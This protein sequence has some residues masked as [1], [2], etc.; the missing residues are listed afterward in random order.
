MLSKKDIEKEL[1]KGIAVV[2]FNKDNLKD[3]S[4]NLTASEYAWGTVSQNYYYNATKDI[5]TIYASER[6]IPEFKRK[7]YKTRYIRAGSSVVITQ[8]N[9]KVILLFPNTT[10]YV[11]TLEVLSTGGSIGGTCHSKVGIAAQGI[12]HIG[13][14]MG[15]N[16][17]GNCFVPL[18][19]PTNKLIV[20]PVGETFMSV[21]FNYLDTPMQERNATTGG[22]T[23]KFSSLGIH[24][25]E[26][27]MHELNQDWKRSHQKVAEQMKSDENFINYKKHLRRQRLSLFFS[28]KNIM[29]GFVLISICIS[30]AVLAAFVDQ[31]AGTTVWSDRFW[32]VMAAGVFL[33]IL[34]LILP[35]R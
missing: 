8:G 7:Y 23:D 32:T 10:T 13:T 3:N 20:L 6:E 14:M 26:E 12:G 24:A 16:Y 30:L 35:K 21:V 22:H 31:K 18:H 19:N 2:P 9:R 34:Q 25:T 5:D 4:I 11:E 28:K 15:P 33:H 1:G 27:E 17:S 29:I